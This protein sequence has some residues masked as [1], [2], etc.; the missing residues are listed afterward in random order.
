[1]NGR[2]QFNNKYLL[3]FMNAKY[4]ERNGGNALHVLLSFQEI[5]NTLIK[6]LVRA[7]FLYGDKEIPDASIILVVLAQNT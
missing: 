3:T 1:M 4:Q 7:C 5:L 2:K 6:I